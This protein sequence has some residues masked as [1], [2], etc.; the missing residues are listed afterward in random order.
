MSSRHPITCHILD[1]SRGKPATNVQC[2]IYR[3]DN[4]KDASEYF[5]SVNVP[6]GTAQ[7]NSD[8][9]VSNWTID[10]PT[11]SE[12]K[13]TFLTR[14]DSG[15]GKW[16]KLVPGVYKIKFETKAYF[17]QASSQS[18]DNSLSSRTF[19]P[20]VEVCFVV[21]SPPDNHY[22]IPLLLSNHSYSTYRGS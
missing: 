18:E 11:G 15:C 17:N 1:T 5:T 2:K 9:R 20:F 22:H 4:V 12:D 8:G 19:F 13:A 7:T 3:I 14:D 21:E 6:F 10:S 16:E